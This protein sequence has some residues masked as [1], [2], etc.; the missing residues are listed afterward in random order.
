M[1]QTWYAWGELRTT[2]EVDAAGLSAVIEEGLRRRASFREVPVLYVLD[3]LHEAGRR[4]ADRGHPVRRQAVATLGDLIGFSPEMVEEGLAT[5]CDI[6]RRDNLRVQVEC[7]LGGPAELLDEFV[8]HDRFRGYVKAVPR[9][10]LAHV[11]AGNVFVGAAD[12]LVR[13]LVTKNVNLLKMSSVDP[14]FPVLF[15]GLLREC[16]PKGDVAGAVA[17]VPFAG[18]SRELEALVK[19]RSDTIMVYGGREAVLAYREGL[20]LHTKLLEYGP[21]YSLVVL[22]AAALRE[23]GLAAVAR[24]VARDFT[25]WNQSA[26]SSPHVVFVDDAALAREF[27]HELARQLEGLL[28]EYPH[29]PIPYQEKVEITRTRELA[30]VEQ[31]LGHGELV[32]PAVDR[33][34]WTVILDTVPKFRVSC[35]HRTAYVKPVRDFDEAA[36]LIGEHGPFIQ[37]VGLL[38]ADASRF[39]L[40]DRLTGVGADRITELGWM[41]RR[42]HGSPHDGGKGLAELVRWVSMGHRTPFVDPFDFQPDELRD[43]KTLSRLNHLVDVARERSAFYR[44]RLPTRALRSLDEVRS[45]PILSQG[46]LRG[47]LPPAGTGILTG[48]L[49]G[50]YAFSSSGT[51]GTPK[52]VYRTVAETHHNAR[53][54]AKGLSLSI[55]EPGDR[56]ANLLF[57]GH[58]W[59]SFVS[60]NQAFERCGALILPIGG[61]IP[62]DVMAAY[63]STFRPDAA[64]SLP[65]VFLGLARHVEEH[66]LDV[67]IRKLITGGEHLW[68]EGRTYLS[69]VLGAE[70]FASTGYTSNDTGAIAFQCARCDGGVHH[71]HEDVHLVEVLDPETLAP[72]PVGTAGKVV[73]TNLHR[74]LMPMIRYDLGDSGRFLKERCGCGRTVRLFELLGRSDETLRVGTNLVP[75][76][77]VARAVGR[78]PGLGQA[79]RMVVSKSGALDRLAVEA[80][81]LQP[82][83]A[84]RARELEQA[85]RAALFAEMEAVVA[86]LTDPSIGALE[87]RVVAPGALPRNPRT[88]K[89]RQV[90]DGRGTS[91][92]SA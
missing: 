37:S 23:A 56:V 77:G 39:A 71:V 28:P 80:E 62:F 48:E 44:D 38:A 8:W 45:I 36:A 1:Q 35:H 5:L 40:A 65:T 85:L 41:T 13:G 17:M 66:G 83:A 91:G 26:C 86:E 82:A 20:G 24:E 68:R 19:E 78:V 27:A 74:E 75:L 63:L 53:A 21:K 22:E 2:G 76:D 32:I 31:A 60:Y 51:T 29:G 6:L 42:K 67:R 54:L 72:V 89:I 57:A 30:R 79:F 49:K 90:V 69:K 34:D 55:L 11:S 18:G 10:L 15:A 92:G 33:Q 59:A 4:L 25:I 58:L 70:R 87:I 73:V 16:D 3:V 12:S 64:I 47:H 9:G 50:A 14:V 61:H 52:S 43:R 46:E 7:D 81:T 88:G 84:E